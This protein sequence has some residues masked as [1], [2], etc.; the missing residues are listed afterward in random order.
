M[1]I[2][3]KNLFS[4]PILLCINDIN[5]GS[6]LKHLEKENIFNCLIDKP[7][8]DH[9]DIVNPNSTCIMGLIFIKEPSLKLLI[10]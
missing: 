5:H 7:I 9:I 2:I 8:I 3:K 1:I 6:P 10:A 4:F